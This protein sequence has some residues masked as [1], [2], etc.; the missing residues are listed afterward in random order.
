MVWIPINDFREKKFL[1]TM[2]AGHKSTIL[3]LANTIINYTLL[4]PILAPFKT[5][6]HLSVPQPKPFFLFVFLNNS[7]PYSTI[8]KRTLNLSLSEIISR[9]SKHMH[10]IQIPICFVFIEVW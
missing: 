1:A 7:Q 9:F 8:P 6:G 10:P 4:R 5:R 3:Y 2:P